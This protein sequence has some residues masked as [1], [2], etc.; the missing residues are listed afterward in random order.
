MIAPVPEDDIIKL[1]LYSISN[2]KVLDGNDPIVVDILAMVAAP[3]LIS[4]VY[5]PACG[6]TTEWTTP[7]PSF[8]GLPVPLSMNLL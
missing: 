2:I 3:S 4:S 5:A 6:N 8:N 1:L 7:E